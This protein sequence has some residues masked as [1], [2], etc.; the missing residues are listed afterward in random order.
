MTY[1]GI[2][3]GKLIELEDSVVLPEGTEVE[4]VVKGRQGE[5]LAPSG[6]P[7]GSARAILAALDLFARCTPEDVDALVEAIGQ[8]KRT[9]RFEGVFDLEEGTK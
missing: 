8:G 3:R 9:L 4:I 6:Y 7:K 5:E 1:K 2:V